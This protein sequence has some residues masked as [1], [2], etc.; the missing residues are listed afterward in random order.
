LSFR[1]K[2]KGLH[3][4]LSISPLT[5]SLELWTPHPPK[6]K[7]NK[8]SHLVMQLPEKYSKT[9]AELKGCNY[10]KIQDP[11]KRNKS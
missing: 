11:I 8:T 1:G 3:P 10:R 7:G 5:N 2:P 9:V 6:N 4:K